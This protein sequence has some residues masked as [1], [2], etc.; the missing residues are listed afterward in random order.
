MKKRLPRAEVLEI[1]QAIEAVEKHI[2]NA[3]GGLPEEVFHFVSRLTPMVNVD[4]LIRDEKGRTL[5]SWR[6][7]PF[8]KPGWHVPGGIIR[9][10]ETFKQRLEK[11]IETE[12]GTDVKLEPSPIAVNE[13]IR[14]WDTRGHF[15]SFLFKGFASSRFIPKNKGLTEKDKG[16]LKWHDSCP[17]DIIEVHEIYRKYI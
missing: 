8:H 2:K 1:R 6:N 3:K 14:E 7:D 17:E 16:Y 5:L 11:V 13:I 15:I 12:I 9:F 4:I 10:K